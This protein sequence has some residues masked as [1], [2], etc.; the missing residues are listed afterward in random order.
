VS[1]QSQLHKTANRPKKRRT[2]NNNRL[3]AKGTNDMAAPRA[4]IRDFELIAPDVYDACLDDVDERDSGNGFYWKWRFSLIVDGE[5]RR[6][7]ANSSLNL[8]KQSKPRKWLAALANRPLQN[9]E[10]VD[11][12]DFYGRKCRLTVGVD[13]TGQYNTVTDVLP[14][15]GQTPLPLP[16]PDNESDDIPF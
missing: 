11:F 6:L 1:T 9:G 12:A 16:N 3:K 14:A 15:R 10:I 7:T 2:K 8:G 13:E 4:K 5:E